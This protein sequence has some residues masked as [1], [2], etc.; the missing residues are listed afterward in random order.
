MLGKSIKNTIRKKPGTQFLLQ[1]LTY[2]RPLNI[3][4]HRHQK[5]KMKRPCKQTVSNYSVTSMLEQIRNTCFVSLPGTLW[6]PNVRMF[7]LCPIDRSN[8]L[9]RNKRVLEKGFISEF[10]CNNGLRWVYLFFFR[11]ITV[12]LFSVISLQLPLKIHAGEN[13][14]WREFQQDLFWQFENGMPLGYC[15]TRLGTWVLD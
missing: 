1:K 15:Q 6:G 7:L 2:P 14:G 8:Q 5:T 4:Q 3:R 12:Y 10:Y 9:S 13:Q 11:F